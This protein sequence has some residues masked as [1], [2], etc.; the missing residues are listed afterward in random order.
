MIGQLEAPDG[1]LTGDSQ[2]KANLLNN[3]YVSVFQ[4]EGL[5]EIPV[6]DDRQFASTL[7]DVTIT[8]EKFLK[9]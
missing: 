3:Y 5:G 7:T 1:S 2:D 4:T 9:Q 8:E 6:F